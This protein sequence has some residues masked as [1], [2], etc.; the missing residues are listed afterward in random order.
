MCPQILA[1][2]LNWPTMWLHHLCW[3]LVTCTVGV[4]ILFTYKQS[5]I[6]GCFWSP[7]L[8]P[9]VYI[10]FNFVFCL[11]T[12]VNLATV[13]YAMNVLFLFCSPFDRGC[14]LYWHHTVSMN[15]LRIYCL[16]LSVTQDFIFLNSKVY[17]SRELTSVLFVLL[18]RQCIWINQTLNQLCS[19]YSNVSNT[20]ML[21]IQV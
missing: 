3:Y 9:N 13:T 14:D 10:V 6:I 19:L 1:H 16:F 18:C 2:I 7:A 8:I 12:I 5:C 21:A 4:C 11:H 20:R 15:F 17:S